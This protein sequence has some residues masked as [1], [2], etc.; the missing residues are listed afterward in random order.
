MAASASTRAADDYDETEAREWLEVTLVITYEEPD[1]MAFD[2]T[3]N[4]HEIYL[5]DP[6][7]QTTADEIRKSFELDGTILISLYQKISELSE[8][9]VNNT[10]DTSLQIFYDPVRDTS[11]FYA[12]TDENR[13]EPP[14]V[15][16]QFC[17][18][19]L[20][21]TAYI[22][23]SELADYNIQSLSDLI[24]G[25]LIM[26]A[27][28]KHNI[29]LYAGAGFSVSY[30]LKVPVYD[31]G[32]EEYKNQM[33][34]SHNK[35]EIYSPNKDT[36]K[37]SL[38][39]LNG[40]LSSVRY[41]KGI[42][43][44]MKSPVAQSYE[45]VEVDLRV[46]LDNFNK[47][48][49]NPSELKINCLNLELTK[50]KFPSNIT[51]LS[52]LS[53]DG[54][55]LF[56][57]N[58][59]ITLND[60]EAELAVETIQLQ[61]QL[62]LAYN[63]SQPVILARTWN[64]STISELDPLYLLKDTSSLTRMGTDRA[65]TGYLAT[66]SAVDANIF[67]NTS[68]TA[69]KGL[70][71]AGGKARL[72]LSLTST[73]GYDYTL[74]MTSGYSLA[75]KTKLDTGIDGV[76]TYEL[77]SKQT[78]NLVVVSEDTVKYSSSK[79]NI[80]VE[81]DIHEVDILSFSDF[82]ASVRIDAQGALNYIKNERGSEFDKALPKEVTMDYYN[83]DALRLM[84]TEGLLDLGEI[85]D[86]LYLIIKENISK[87]L[88]EKLKMRVSFNEE[89]L[90]FDGDIEHMDGNDPVPFRIRANGQM[91][92]TEDK[93]VRMGG[94]ITK[95][96][97]L[98]LQGVKYWNVTY[99]LILP[100]HINILG[101][102]EIENE[103]NNSNGYFGPVV[104]RNSDGRYEL[105][106]TILG[107]PRAGGESSTAEA[108]EDFEL[109]INVDIDIT[110][111]FFL[112]KII[113]PIIL[114]VILSIVIVIVKLTYRYR[115]KKLEKLLLDPDL[116]ME[117][118]E[119]SVKGSKVRRGGRGR[120]RMQKRERDSEAVAKPGM[121]TETERRK[122]R[123][124]TAAYS[125]EDYSERLK[126]LK[127]L[128]AMGMDIEKPRS[129]RGRGRK[130]SGKSRSRRRRAVGRSRRRPE[131]EDRDRRRST[132]RDRRDRDRDYD[133]DSYEYP[134]TRRRSRRGR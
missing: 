104:K 36:L 55:R 69:I 84:Y 116:D 43:L 85:E 120:S 71:N 15:V 65:I 58:G 50:H 131:Y 4:I 93:L 83:S 95:Q 54:L 34:I 27:K 126:E 26:G 2:I 28:V 20:N 23:A 108:S 105:T 41:I 92:I 79:A 81:I 77:T 38:D 6:F 96:I 127:P 113:I 64:I 60:I 63:T 73:L 128:R 35:N 16:R 109:V 110:L 76:N 133:N 52:V 115:T 57:N 42:A 117:D 17:R 90:N 3:Y 7:G 53:A 129:R 48:T 18:I 72:D 8:R 37:F 114:F 97:E 40:I 88:E 33:A 107:E 45:T 59:I 21:H 61:N 118:I 5:I 11:S 134:E 100:E 86:S 30:F 25:S 62:T 132:A 99:K 87:L 31:P 78:S 111:W 94:F 122:R 106:A 89:L 14:V 121:R 80:T 70:L 124:K 12:P 130:G 49:I 39:N 24:K 125:E 103:F 56:Y 98:P 9:F 46:K 47:L 119:Y 74:A 91:M 32:T 29:K 102:P 112:S 75:G 82:L 10:I 22:K 67:G 66:G 68:I 13:Y 101:N 1:W 123:S 19:K 51:E 44:R